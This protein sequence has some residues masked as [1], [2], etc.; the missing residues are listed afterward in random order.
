VKSST[1]VADSKS[2]TLFESSCAVCH[3]LDGGGGEHAPKIGRASAA[4]SKSDSVLAGILRNGIPSKGMPSFASLG[5]SKLQSILSYLRFL[6]G[7]NETRTDTGNP[8]RGKQ[9]F[10]G[11]GGCADCH[12]MH[13][14]GHYLSTDLSDFAYDHDLADILAAIVKPQ[15]QVPHTAVRFTTNSGGQFSGVIRNESNYSLQIQ[16]ADGEFYLFMK[17][18]LRSMERSPAPAMPADY[19]QKLSSS[20]IDDLVSYIAHQSPSSQAGDSQPAAHRKN[21]EME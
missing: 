20:E 13:G 1:H 7:K 5:A 16:G 9:V 2:K 14:E 3:G 18:E 12:A 15:E 8:L 11:K 17:S 19:Q 4:R 21:S 6:Q 10:F